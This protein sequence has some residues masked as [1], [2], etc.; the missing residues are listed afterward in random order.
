M[1]FRPNL[2]QHLLHRFLVWNASL[3]SGRAATIRSLKLQKMDDIVLS[4]R[5]AAL[6]KGDI[7][8]RGLCNERLRK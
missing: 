4:F 2:S 8:V 3:P 6:R 1:T 7:A 5:D